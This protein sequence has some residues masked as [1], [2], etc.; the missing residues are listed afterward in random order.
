MVN[1]KTMV[2][3]SLLFLC[4]TPALAFYEETLSR[5]QGQAPQVDYLPAVSSEPPST[6]GNVAEKPLPSF[7][8]VRTD[9]EGISLQP[10]QNGAVGRNIPTSP[11]PAAK[12]VLPVASVPSPQVITPAAAAPAPVYAA[13]IQ[14][15]GVRFVGKQK[16]ASSSSSRGKSIP[17][18]T[19]LQMIAP[20]GWDIE[21][22]AFGKQK[23]S[24]DASGKPWTSVVDTMA[25]QVGAVVTVN[26]SAG[27][28]RCSA[29]GKVSSQSDPIP[30]QPTASASPQIQGGLVKKAIISTPGSGAE[31]AKRYKLPV[32]EFCRWNAFGKTT[33]LPAGYEVYLTPPPAGTVIV[34]N[35]PATPELSEA[36]YAPAGGAHQVRQTVMVATPA[37]MAPANPALAASPAP[38]QSALALPAPSPAPAMQQVNPAPVAPALPVEPAPAPAPEPAPVV[39]APIV[40][41]PATPVMAAPVPAPQ[42]KPRMEP[43][44]APV[45]AA[46]PPTVDDNPQQ[47]QAWSLNPGPL[48]PQ[49][50]AWS[51]AAGYQL[52]WNISRDFSISSFASYSGDFKSALK[53]VLL[54]LS[55]QGF[56]IRI[57]LSNA[58]KV[59]VVEE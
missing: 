40:E 36:E 51:A 12:P 1:Y 58:N 8:A 48:S 5:G 13:P 17:F 56:P 4:G 42:Q 46:E 2:A 11:M 18:K 3:A 59:V 29:P 9:I 32:D 39:V 25:K 16:N 37:G 31:V 35:M 47:I 22:G 24:W 33:P 44:A 45:R 50:S 6:A 14:S 34:A 10:G 23:V 43:I 30:A 7:D 26:W 55:S 53:R 49:L 20:K 57:R 27:S 19:A 28:I 52:I 15:P 54:D 21:T 41:A 38:L